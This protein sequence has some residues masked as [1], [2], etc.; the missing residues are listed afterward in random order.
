MTK[1][2]IAQDLY[3]SF[4]P[5]WNSKTFT[6][7]KNRLQ[8]AIT[9]L[10][11]SQPPNFLS[12]YRIPNLK[13]V[14]GQNI[15]DTCY[16]YCVQNE[17]RKRILNVKFYDEMMDLISRE[18]LFTIGSRASRIVGSKKDLDSFD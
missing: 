1:L 13:V 5:K 18:D 15:L 6:S 17:R 14:R 10:F 4:I 3:G 2:D 11:T 16:Q 7:I 9:M 12:L 8:G